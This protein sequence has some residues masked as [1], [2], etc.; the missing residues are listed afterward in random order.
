MD[1]R[2][3]WNGLGP[4]RV[5]SLRMPVSI[6]D[7]NFWDRRAPGVLQLEPRKMQMHEELLLSHKQVGGGEHRLPFQRSQE[8][9]SWQA[10]LCL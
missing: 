5:D 4:E 9:Q 1:S 2:G 7:G 3:S 10:P 6:S 8:A